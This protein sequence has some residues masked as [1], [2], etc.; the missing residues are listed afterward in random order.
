MQASV[1]KEL[2]PI[3]S[4]SLMSI[5]SATCAIFLAAGQAIFQD[6]LKMHL[7]NK[8]PSELI[9]RILDSGATNIRSF[10]SPADLPI[11]IESYSKSITQIFVCG[12]CSNSPRLH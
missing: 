10:I 5:V 2:V 12:S 7:S 1:S 8:L 6:R 3:A 11:V 9:A 4:G